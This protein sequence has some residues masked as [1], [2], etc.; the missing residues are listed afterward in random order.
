MAHVQQYADG[1]YVKKWLFKRTIFIENEQAI[2]L[3][4]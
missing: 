2:F 4:W 1:L 3:L